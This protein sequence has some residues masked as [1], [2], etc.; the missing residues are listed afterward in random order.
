MSEESKYDR[1]R[2]PG[3]LVTTVAA[4]QLGKP[5]SIIGEKLKAPDPP[6]GQAAP[7]RR[8]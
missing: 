1:R 2:F 6:D 7:W 8:A 5:L 3:T 4:S